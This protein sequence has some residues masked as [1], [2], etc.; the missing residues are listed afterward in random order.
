MPI[1]IPRKGP[2]IPEEQPPMTEE[3]KKLAWENVV[4]AWTEVNQEQFR[5]LLNSS[6]SKTLNE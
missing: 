4:K 3:Q 2:I 6:V 1:I 5:E